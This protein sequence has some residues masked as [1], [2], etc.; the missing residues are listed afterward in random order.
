MDELGLIVLLA[1]VVGVAFLVG[2]EYGRANTLSSIE[3]L[4]ASGRQADQELAGALMAAASSQDALARVL[5]GDNLVVG[6]PGQALE[7]TLA[8]SSPAANDALR[9]P[10]D[11]PGIIRKGPS[12]PSA[13]LSRPSAH[14]RPCKICDSVRAFFAR[15]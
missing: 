5:K 6:L 9:E 2:F 3:R 15:S 14:E 7:A 13:R 12:R 10:E 4:L 1:V 11:V 8:A